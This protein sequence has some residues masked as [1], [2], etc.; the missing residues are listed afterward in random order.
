VSSVTEQNALL[1]RN[2]MIAAAVVETAAA[3]I[4]TYIAG[5]DPS[6]DASAATVLIVTLLIVSFADIVLLRVVVLSRLASERGPRRQ[7]AIILA[8][9]YSNAI[10]IFGLVAAIVSGQGLIA[11]PF[12]AISFLSF[13]VLLSYVDEAYPKAPDR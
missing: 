5:V 12:A 6:L 1:T 3:F 8:S 11:L 7:T 2:L 4:V 9:A 13:Y 10:A